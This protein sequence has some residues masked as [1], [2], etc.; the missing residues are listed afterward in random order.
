MFRCL[1]PGSIL[2]L[3]TFSITPHS[4]ASRNTRRNTWSELLTE[5]TC[6]PLASRQAEKSAAFSLV[7]LS[8]R[9]E[10]KGAYEA[11]VPR[12]GR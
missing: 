7:I 12:L 1:S 4:I 11:I 10:A 3:G 9:C 2:I 6:N 8:S 5:L